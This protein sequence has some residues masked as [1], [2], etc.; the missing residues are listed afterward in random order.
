MELKKNEEVNN[1]RLRFPMIF[2]GMLFTGSLVLAS[3]TYSTPEEDKGISQTDVRETETS[4]EDE[5]KDEPPPKVPEVE[6]QAPITPPPTEETPEEETKPEPPAREPNPPAPPIKKG[7]EIQPDII[8]EI[9]EFPA[10]DAT[11]PGGTL[12]MKKWIQEN[13]N[14]PEISRELGDQGRVYVTFVIEQDGSITGIG[15]MR[16]GVTDE[17]NREAKRLIRNM[18]KWIPG[19]DK[20]LAVRSRCRLPITFTLQ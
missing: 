3:F 9:V 5:P 20:G 18:P 14:Y 16:G 2:V 13:V 17:L 12:A 11:F 7:P 4:Y 10:V 6:Q 19:N 15:I 1:D 8:P